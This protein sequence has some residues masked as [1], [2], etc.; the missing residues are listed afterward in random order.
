MNP[1]I[2]SKTLPGMISSIASLT[3]EKKIWCNTLLFLP[4]TPLWKEALACVKQDGRHSRWQL[5]NLCNGSIFHHCNSTHLTGSVLRLS[6]F[7]V[8]KGRPT[9]SVIR[10]QAS[11]LNISTRSVVPS[12]YQEPQLRLTRLNYRKQR[13]FCLMLLLLLG[14]TESPLHCQSARLPMNWTTDLRLFQTLGKSKP[15]SNM[16]I[17]GKQQVLTVCLRGSFN[18]FTKN[19]HLLY[20]ILFV[21][22]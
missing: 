20:T 1:A 16:W 12:S 11:G 6:Y 10:I 8:M 3:R 21:P 2:G 17:R 13:T 5:G 18:G 4:R 15:Y 9:I 14:R 19:W 22:V 7:H